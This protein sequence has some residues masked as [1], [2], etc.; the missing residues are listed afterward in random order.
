MSQY[1]TIKQIRYGRCICCGR[2]FPLASY[3]RDENGE[4]T[5]KIVSHMNLRC[6]PCLSEVGQ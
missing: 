4:L 1:I 3:E 6:R 5:D 2:P